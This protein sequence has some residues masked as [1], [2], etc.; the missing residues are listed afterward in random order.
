MLAY[1]N[2][3]NQLSVGDGTI[4]GAINTLSA[5][6]E[7]I[8]RPYESLKIQAHGIISQKRFDS[9]ENKYRFTIFI[10]FT[11]FYALKK[12]N[13]I[14]VQYIT[15]LIQNGEDVNGFQCVGT[16]QDNQ[17]FWLDFIAHPDAVDISG[18]FC[19]CELELYY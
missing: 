6:L 4:I 14:V 9:V 5:G 19:D 16:A 17:G 13:I 8:I 1:F 2:G 11:H 15:F 3:N 18:Y 12:I 7:Q 10:P